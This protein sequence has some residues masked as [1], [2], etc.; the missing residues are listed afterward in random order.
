MLVEGRFVLTIWTS[1]ELVIVRHSAEQ[2]AIKVRWR[3]SQAETKSTLKDFSG[4]MITVQVI[5]HVSY[6]KVAQ[7]DE[8]QITVNVQ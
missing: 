8:S 7:N 4:R 6:T 2:K 5:L 1:F 3:F